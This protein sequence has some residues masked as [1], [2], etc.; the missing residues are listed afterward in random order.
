MCYGVAFIDDACKIE[1]IYHPKSIYF[2]AGVMQD[3]NTNSDQ[4]IYLL[5]GQ[6]IKKL[7]KNIHAN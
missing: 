5:H 2:D 1:I 7:K 4:Y 6:F 3:I